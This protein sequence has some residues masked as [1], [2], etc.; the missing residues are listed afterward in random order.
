[1]RNSYDSKD[2]FDKYAVLRKNPL[3]YNEIVEMPEM[4]RN[5]PDLKNKAILDIG[6]G[7]GHLIEHMGKYSTYNIMGIDL[8]SR[9]IDYCVSNYSFHNVE[10]KQ[11]NFTD[12]DFNQ[13]FDVIVSSLVFHYFEDFNALCQKLSSIMNKDG[14]L[15]FS[16]EHPIVTAGK[17]PEITPGNVWLKMDHYF[18]ESERRMYWK[19]LDN[20]IDKYHHTIGTI[21]NSLIQNGFTIEK[22]T[23]LGQSKEVFESYSEERIEKL[24]H[25]PPF[26]MVKC[27]KV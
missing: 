20:T 3:S 5:L 12:I 24:S 17:T 18:E 2:I 8:S 6:C 11:G 25:Y 19:G 10:F 16:M 21:L 23:E 13:K 22:I 9:M 1:M 27:K 7:M 14:T 26:I 4:K 15:L